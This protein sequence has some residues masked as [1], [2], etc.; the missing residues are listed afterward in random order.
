ML[1]GTF[2]TSP[3]K[4]D[5]APANTNESRGG[6]RILAVKTIGS[7]PG[8]HIDQNTMQ[9]ALTGKP[10]T[11]RYWTFGTT[12]KSL[13]S[14]NDTQFAGLCMNCHT[15]A[16]LNNTAVASS[17]NW[18]TSSRIHN[19]VAGWAL[20]T[21]TAGNLNN[22]VHSYTCSKCHSSHNSNLPRLLITNCLDVKHRGRVTTGGVMSVAITGVG[23]RNS[24]QSRFPGGGGTA[25]G[26]SSTNPGPWFFGKTGTA[27][28][29]STCHDGA[30]AGGT[31]STTNQQWNSKSPW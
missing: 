30:N 17:A 10:N 5:A 6:G 27:P 3:Y 9:A 15:K 16:T 31:F 20:S 19:A 14:L 7:T 28:Y 25:N 18:K 1:K 12:A 29:Y 4:Q 22:K 21:G 23:S 8:Y 26:K 2:V 13:Q 11:A 24:G